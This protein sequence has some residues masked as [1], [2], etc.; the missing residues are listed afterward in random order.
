M[1]ITWQEF[2]HGD[3]R[4]DTAS[5][6]SFVTDGTLLIDHTTSTDPYYHHIASFGGRMP[7]YHT[8]T[9]AVIAGVI[10]KITHLGA[11]HAFLMLRLMSFFSGC[12]LLWLVFLRARQLFGN[13]HAVSWAVWITA[14]CYPLIDYSANGSV[15]SAQTTLFVL[16]LCCTGIQRP[17]RRAGVLGFLAA[18][19]IPL[20]QPGIALVPLG[21]AWEL[22]TTHSWRQKVKS[23]FLILSLGIIGKM[24]I[25]AY[26]MRTFGNPF[27]LDEVSAGYVYQKAGILPKVQNGVWFYVVPWR[28]KKLILYTLVT[29][30]FPNNVYYVIRKLLVLVPIAFPVLSFGI[31]DQLF[32][33]QRRHRLKAELL[34]LV[35]YGVLIT[36]WPTTHFRFFITL[37]PIII[38]LSAEAIFALPPRWKRVFA[39]TSI[40][41]LLCV[42]VLAYRSNPAHMAYYDGAITEDANHRNGELY[43]INEYR[44]SLPTNP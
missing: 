19:A 20:H 8:P 38:L 37:L 11:Q 34:M 40:V 30:W 17:L 33:V 3:V 12:A 10:A 2:P 43:F 36:A 28:M 25:W 14:L 39:V 44:N 21:I 9:W 18:I 1:S 27:L 23:V 31:I 4:T 6:Q 7:L 42:D 5:V 35:M 41:V 29:R 26:A 16:W 15:Y 24:L 32:S 22:S 13:S